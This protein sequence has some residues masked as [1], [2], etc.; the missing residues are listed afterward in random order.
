[1]QRGGLWGYALAAGG[2]REE[3]AK[4]LRRCLELSKPLRPCDVA[5]FYAGLGDKDKALV[6]LDRAFDEHAPCMIV[7]KVEPFFD[8]LRSTPRFQNLLRR[9][10]FPP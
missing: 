5:M 1:M 4:M 6:W 8:S 9:M 3:A 10:N 7:L 2:R